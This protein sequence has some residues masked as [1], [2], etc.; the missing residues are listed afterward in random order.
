MDNKADKLLCT[1]HIVNNYIP[2]LK[3]LTL[4]L[5]IKL[6]TCFITLPKLPLNHVIE[7]ISYN[8]VKLLYVH[9]YY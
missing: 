4:P 1:C 3:F 5:N 9:N 7:Q 2:T 8:I 6:I